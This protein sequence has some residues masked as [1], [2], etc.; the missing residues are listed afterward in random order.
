MLTVAVVMTVAASV[1]LI[2]M[3]GV[4]QNAVVSSLEFTVTRVIPSLFCFMV[5]SRFAASIDAAR[6]L[7]PIFKPLSKILH[8]SDEETGCFITGNLCGFPTGAALSADLISRK[9]FSGTR[10]VTLVALSNNISAGFMVSFVGAGI[11]ASAKIGAIL[12]ACQLAAAGIVCGFLRRG[13]NT[14][15]VQ[16]NKG[17][18]TVNI[19]SALVEAVK[20]G[21]VSS[22]YLTGFIVTF[23]VIATYTEYFMTALGLPDALSAPISALLEVTRGCSAAPELGEAASFLLISFSAG[24][25]GLCV[26]FQSAS[27]FV[28]AG[29]RVKDY[30]ALKLAQG[31]VSALLAAVVYYIFA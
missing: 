1:L 3:P 23:T 2:A 16:K 14:Y 10:A 27:F 24:F 17:E 22:I 9:G 30:I 15:E 6:I 12:W 25:S 8:L 13:I 28:G 11:F 29:V 20:G 7:R 26:I 21:A 19:S 31:T 4:A 5:L 18:R